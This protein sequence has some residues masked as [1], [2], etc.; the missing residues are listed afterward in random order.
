MNEND[1]PKPESCPK[2]GIPIPADAPEGLCPRCLGAFNLAPDTVFTE[3]PD[4]APHTTP[5]SP[6]EIAPHF[7]QLEILEC[8]G[9][10]GMGVVY[11]ARQRTLGRLV[12][13]KL[14]A[15]ERVKDPAFAERFATEAKALAAMNHPNI[16]TIHDFG[17]TN[18][19]YFLLMELVDGVNLRQAMKGGRFTPEEALAI[20][21]TVCEALHYAHERGIVHRDIKP[22]NLLMNKEGQVMIADFGIAK[23]LDGETRGDDET[24]VVGTPRYMAPEQIEN[25]ALTDSRADIY[26]LGVVLYEMLT[27]EEP[28]DRIEPPS[29]K[30]KNVRI[31][32]RLDEVVLRALAEEP[33][34]RFQTA[35]DFKTGLET[36]V[37]PTAASPTMSHAPTPLTSSA[38]RPWWLLALGSLWLIVALVLM[39]GREV[40]R[41]QPLM[42]H[43]F[44]KGAW[45]YPGTYHGLVIASVLIGAVFFVVWWRRG[46]FALTISR[47]QW[48][49]A[50]G[51]CGAVLLINLARRG[52]QVVHLLLAVGILVII[53][54]V[55]SWSR[56]RKRHQSEATGERRRS[57]FAQAAIA[58]SLAIFGIIIA[59]LYAEW[60]NDSAGR[61]VAAIV[62]ILI[63][64]LATALGVSAMLALREKDMEQRG[65]FFAFF[66]AASLPVVLL[67]WASITA[68][69]IVNADLN[70]QYIDYRTQL[71]KAESASETESASTEEDI[72]PPLFPT[73]HRITMVSYSIAFGIPVLVIPI[74]AT[75]CYRRF[76]PTRKRTG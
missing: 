15:P 24:S 72:R 13:L 48:I 17:E 61:T 26:S 65:Y 33:E 37:N 75:I 71:R 5:P 20:V 40:A 46:K 11:K 60:R 10:G 70:Q 16:V 30:A 9:R 44:G 68:A 42:Y 25:P 2:C 49:W 58:A 34:M 73:K 69:S 43:F 27:G 18:G 55:R 62:A 35:G 76:H 3:D 23:I 56:R 38:D 66:G 29:A 28:G 36:V 45:L 59:Y 39:L 41:T 64:F 7:P 57:V 6:E 22:E 1:S 53:L 47:T 63:T 32:V 8:L 74:V 14:L 51:I 21:P 12:A 67:L 52:L 4:P 54:L 31:D 50:V 19:F